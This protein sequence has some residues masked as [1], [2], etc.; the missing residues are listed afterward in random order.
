MCLGKRV[1]LAQLA[2]HRSLDFAMT[3]NKQ[4]AATAVHADMSRLQAQLATLVNEVLLGAS[5]A[6]A[7]LHAGCLLLTSIPGTQ[8]SAFAPG[9]LVAASFGKACAYADGTQLAAF[10]ISALLLVLST[11]P[12]TTRV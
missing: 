12:V 8:L 4:P 10:C 6:E 5:P 9:D 7:G 11:D 3:R 1:P 2:G